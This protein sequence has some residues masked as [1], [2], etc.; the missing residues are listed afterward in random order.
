MIIILQG[1]LL[2]GEIIGKKSKK[3][4]IYKSLIESRFI[5]SSTLVISSLLKKISGM[6]SLSVEIKEI[7]IIGLFDAIL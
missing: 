4:R 6:I 3:G 1:F 5:S 2:T 7:I